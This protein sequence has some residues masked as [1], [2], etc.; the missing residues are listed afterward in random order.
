MRAR[1]PLCESSAVARTV[2]VVDDH[3]GFRAV[4]RALLEAAG[5]EVVGEAADG[6][7]AISLCASRDPDLVLLDIQLP[8]I[9]G[10]EVRE[11]LL[12][13]VHPPAVLLTSVR[14][15]TAYGP[16]LRGLKPIPFVSKDELSVAAIVTLLDAR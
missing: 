8:D 1:V 16:R 6:A 4:A 12:G 15:A 2:L 9:D 14:P 3:A 11:R 10:F 5:I 13:T 7:E